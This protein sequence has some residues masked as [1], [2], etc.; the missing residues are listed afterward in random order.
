MP[1]QHALWTVT[2]QPKELLPSSLVAEQLLED[3]II[4]SPR[5]LSDEWMLIGRQVDTGFGG[6]IDLLAIAPDGTLVLIELKR[7]R[8]PRAVVAQ[9]LDYACWV[10]AL[11][12]DDIATIYSRFAPGKN[13]ATDFRARFGQPLDEDNLNSSH[14]I[15]VVA[16]SL[17]ASTE[18]IVNYLSSRD[19]AINVLCFQVFQNGAEQL[20]SR[21]WLLDPVEAQVNA[22][23][24]THG[25]A[26]ES[27]NGEFYASFGDGLSRS[28]AEAVRYGFVCAGGGAWYSNTLNLL[29]PGDRIWVKV[30][31][32][33]F[34]GV[35][36]VRGHRLS[37][38]E[39]TIEGRPCLEVL[40]SADYHRALADDF[41]RCEYF[42]PVDWLETT[43][44]ESAIQ[45]LGMF[46]N[47][48]TV[49]K[50]KTPLWRAT[51]ERL[52][53]RFPEFDGQPAG[54]SV[55]L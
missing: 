31:A 39:F 12:P 19:V 52:K 25:E 9:A 37:A 6:R 14:Q 43:S 34:V 21:A 7:D 41:E 17:D 24:A 42:V 32:R 2:S 26:K 47:Q 22:A 1:I 50:P 28:W 38:S 48:N 40:T 54:R 11:K 49:C 16:A 45:E 27:W 30:P 35:G 18:R 10:E 55:P 15:V 5:I 33:G 8:T 3:M 51:V 23:A 44:L 36:R 13:L 46:G 53:Q 20:L 29:N 4:S